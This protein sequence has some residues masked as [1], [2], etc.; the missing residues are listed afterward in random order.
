MT[1]PRY[2]PLFSPICLGSRITDLE[3]QSV[4][5]AASI[6]R[7]LYTYA[8]HEEPADAFILLSGADHG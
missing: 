3:L 1:C 4:G 5:Q 2:P 7:D 8:P 6:L